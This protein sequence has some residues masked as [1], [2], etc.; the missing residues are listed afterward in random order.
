[1]TDVGLGSS[2]FRSGVKR[3]KEPRDYPY[4]RSPPRGSPP[5]GRY[6]RRRSPPRK[7]RRDDFERSSISPERRRSYD[8]FRD[9]DDS[10][11]MRRFGRS[12]GEDM[13]RLYD[14]SPLTY[15]QFLD[16][17]E[18]SHYGSSRRFSYDDYLQEYDKKNMKTFFKAHKGE[19]WFKEKYHPLCVEENYQENKERSQKASAQFLE[20]LKNGLLDNF[21]LDADSHQSELK[22]FEQRKETK[23][24]QPEQTTENKEDTSTPNGE[25]NIKSEK[26][27]TE[28]SENPSEPPPEN[29]KIDTEE[30][31]K[32]ISIDEEKPE[33]NKL[34]PRRSPL[35]LLE[36]PELPNTIKIDKIP[37]TCSRKAL[38]GLL[39]RVTTGIVENLI[40]SEPHPVKKFKR[41]AWVTFSTEEAA[42]EALEK[43]N[44][45]HYPTKDAVLELS[46]HK[47]KYL[48]LKPIL[49]PSI[50]STPARIQK[51]LELSK[52]LVRHFDECKGIE[53]SV[54]G[55]WVPRDS[56][57]S[58]PTE[59]NMDT[60]AVSDTN[61][62][63]VENKLSLK[64]EK[65]L[66]DITI[67]YLRRV[68]CHNYYTC[69]TF[70][71]FSE[72]SV[73][74]P[75]YR[76][77]SN[78]YSYEDPKHWTRELERKVDE[79]VSHEVHQSKEATGEAIIEKK[80]E[81]FFQEKTFKENE[82]RFR[83]EICNKM[84]KAAKFVHKHLTVKH[85]DQI[86]KIKQEAYD[87][88]FF[89]NFTNDS[90]K[91]TPSSTCD[92]KEDRINRYDR[93]PRRDTRD[94][95]PPPREPSRERRRSNNWSGGRGNK[96]RYGLRNFG[97]GRDYRENQRTATPEPPP[98]L[99]DKVDPRQPLDYRD[100]DKP[101]E[102][103]FEIDY[104]KALAA[105][106]SGAQ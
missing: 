24:T 63:E 42:K 18:G 54:L 21:N 13:Q 39:S 74:A 79:K 11:R 8:R 40:I 17:V 15:N 31:K 23:E 50:A 100:L 94:R 35:S 14:G 75:V 28:M 88:Q 87:N 16:I 7:R 71:N 82:E 29:Q 45:Q 97:R 44:G 27:D 78:Y 96:R 57:E 85:C 22:D 70:K 67:E 34:K 66:L 64:S 103:N 37:P 90:N 101:P 19:E 77:T 41:V 6:D 38:F 76:G 2:D 47:Q 33:E 102:D 3:D 98:E 72:I 106:A 86:D 69:E 20:D 92:N 49:T 80:L 1:M 4:R 105:F 9:R 61:R 43:F 48:P 52:K 53:N 81:E 62:S 99:K 65:E 93:S 89:L 32:P 30:E 12:P 73:Q 5:R 60:N 51:D 68:H 91:I 58:K 59:D 55:K 56:N 46:V 104:E 25:D 95:T 36:P 84:F 26:Q 10:P 83:C